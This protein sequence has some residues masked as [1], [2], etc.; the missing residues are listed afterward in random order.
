MMSPHDKKPPTGKDETQV[1]TGRKTTTAARAPQEPAPKCPRCDS[2]NTKFCYYNNYSLTQPRHFCKTCRRYWTKGGA[3]RNVPIGGGCRKSKKIKPSPRDSGGSSDIGR[4]KFFEGISPA[5]DFQLGGINFPKIPPNTGLFNQLSSLDNSS[6]TC[7]AISSNPCFNLLD[8][9][10]GTSSS[11]MGFKF[12]EMGSLNFHNSLTSSIESLS[13]INQD[14]H[15]KLQRQRLAMLFAGDNNYYYQKENNYTLPPSSETH[16]QYQKL[17]NLDISKRPEISC[18]KLDGDG[19]GGTCGNNINISLST[20]WFFDNSYVTMNPT[21]AG[22]GYQ[23]QQL[24]WNSGFILKS[25]VLLSLILIYFIFQFSF[26]FFVL[27]VIL[28]SSSQ[29]VASLVFIWC[30]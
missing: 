10:A 8:P 24:E 14:L 18:G 12:Q 22:P 21:P 16:V 25:S 26:P 1:S 23:Q 6:N 5:M 3:L 29:N 2:S 11:S 9:S 4:L 30:S 17:Q 7:C 19:G 15:W 27:I 20:E 13:S 28:I